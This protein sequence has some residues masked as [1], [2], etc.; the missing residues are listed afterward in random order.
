MTILYTVHCMIYVSAGQRL[1][2]QKRFWHT[3]MAFTHP[4]SWRQTCRKKDGM[5]WLLK[6]LCVGTETKARLQILNKE[7][8]KERK[9]ERKTDTE[10]YNEALC[11]S[12]LLQ[13]QSG[14]NKSKHRGTNKVMK[15]LRNF[16]QDD[17]FLSFAARTP[18]YQS[19]IQYNANVRVIFSFVL[20]A[21]ALEIIWHIN[22]MD[23]SLFFTMHAP[24]PYAFKR[25]TICFSRGPWKR[26]L[27]P[28]QRNKKKENRHVSLKSPPP[29][30]RHPFGK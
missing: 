17:T 28:S 1:E 5:S 9:G 21:I 13:R 7:N 25:E 2:T 15:A 3:K 23:I 19:D 12:K 26:A 6:L 24:L 22:H 14:W 10:R 8:D 27:M 18:A 4:P 30:L 11:P 20:P 16:E 29:P